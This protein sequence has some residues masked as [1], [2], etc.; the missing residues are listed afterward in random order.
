VTETIKIHFVDSPN[1]RITN[2][3]WRTAAIL[4]NRKRPYLTNALTDLH[5]I[6]LDDAFW[7]YEGYGQLKSPTFKNP[8]WRTAAIWKI[9]NH[10]ISATPW[11]ICTKFDTKTH[12]GPPKTM[13][14]QNFKLLK[15]Q[16]NS[17]WKSEKHSPFHCIYGLAYGLL[18]RWSHQSSHQYCVISCLNVSLQITENC[19]YANK[20]KTEKSKWKQQVHGL[21]SLSK[22]CRDI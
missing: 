15:I 22:L 18:S 12:F 9:E 20:Q 10:H 11:P 16:G 13:G 17:L 21:D 4:N 5:K 7:P 3:R 14:R 6:W 2:P 19:L 8:R 1:R